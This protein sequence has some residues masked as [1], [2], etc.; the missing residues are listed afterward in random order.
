MPPTLRNTKVRQD[1]NEEKSKVQG[2]FKPTATATQLLMTIVK[3]A[4]V[5]FEE[6]LVQTH[7]SSSNYCTATNF[8]YWQML[9]EMSEG[10]SHSAQES[11]AFLQNGYNN[12]IT[13]LQN[14]KETAILLKAQ[15]KRLFVCMDLISENPEMSANEFAQILKNDIQNTNPITNNKE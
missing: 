1:R 6:F 9:K 14:N 2:V 8:A 12:Q 5:Q 4:M 11:R 13:Q 15:T 10:D 3:I 7:N